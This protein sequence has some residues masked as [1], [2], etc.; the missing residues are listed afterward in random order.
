M[1]QIATCSKQK[2]HLQLQL[3]SLGPLLVSSR[4]V[5][6]YQKMLYL[7]L[8]NCDFLKWPFFDH[9][10]FLNWIYFN[11][12][13]SEHCFRHNFCVVWKPFWVSREPRQILLNIVKKLTNHFHFNDFALTCLDDFKMIFCTMVG[14]SLDNFCGEFFSLMFYKTHHSPGRRL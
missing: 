9:P 3:W 7:L 11:L 1:L 6:E 5:P 13:Y 10:K 14:E 8:L 12:S 2:F 4:L